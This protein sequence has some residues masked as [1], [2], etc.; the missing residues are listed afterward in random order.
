[1]VFPCDV[2]GSWVLT[3]RTN[4]P[5]HVHTLQSPRVHAQPTV[6]LW[7]RRSHCLAQ[8]SFHVV[9]ELVALRAFRSHGSDA[10]AESCAAGTG[11]VA[12]AN[13]GNPTA[14]CADATAATSTSADATAAAGPGTTRC[15]SNSHNRSGETVSA[16]AVEH[17]RV[18]QRPKVLVKRG[19]VANMVVQDQ[20]GR[21][22]DE[23]R[24]GENIG[25]SW[26]RRTARRS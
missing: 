21:V 23:G 24:V 13:G 19:P 14:A 3:S 15:T 17:E 12:A 10:T 2:V 9:A 1:M 5:S 4:T 11:P 18:R 6:I 7:R 25:R 16:S 20:D 26:G 22:R 8:E